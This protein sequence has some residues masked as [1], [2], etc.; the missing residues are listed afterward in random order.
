MSTRH[1]V[2]AGASAA[3]LTTAENL[4]KRGYAGK[5]TLVGAE[6]HLPY[7]RPPLSKQILAGTWAPERVRLREP[8]VLAGLDATLL[9]GHRATGLDLA[10]RRISLDDGTR[11]GFDTLVVATGVTP[12]SLPGADLDGVH[13]LRILDDALALRAGL[14]AGPKVVVVGAGFLGAEVAAVARAMGLDVTLLDPLPVPMRRQFGDRIGELVGRLH[15]DHGT[16]L[17]CG[18]GVARFLG[19]GGR[20]VGVEL[21][22]GSTV[23]ADLVL[24]AVG[25]IPATGWLKGSGLPLGDG[26]ECDEYGQAAPG[27]YAAG[28][29][30]SWPN[31][32]FGVRLR[33]EH[34]MNATEQG[35]AVA[36]AIVGE[37]KPFAPVPYFWS[38]QYDTKI[39]A[40]GI[41]PEDARV[42][43]LDGTFEDRKFVAAY[44]RDDTVVGVLGWN[45]PR[46]TRA[47]RKLVAD[48]AT[49]QIS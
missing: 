47:A 15:R 7:D 1:V 16:R 14:L 35:M 31:G 3:G 21:A 39:Q 28:D 17:R 29:V 44:L 13:R 37:A 45:D 36:A 23:D 20:V 26:V 11:L 12:R 33:L 38:D 2:V 24:V 4:R 46:G 30:A 18:T 42:S 41:F 6:P 49:P 8:D 27:V 19:R 34:R 22:D 5:L 32:H 48:R 9:L 25:S 10:T 43:V 40:Y